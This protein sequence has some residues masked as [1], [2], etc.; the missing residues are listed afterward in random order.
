MPEGCAT[1]HRH[2]SIIDSRLSQ[3][4]LNFFVR[5]LFIFQV[6]HHQVIVGFGDL[7]DERR[8]IVAELFDHLFRHR[9]FD[10]VHGA[11]LLVGVCSFLDE[12]DYA[13]EIILDANRDLYCHGVGFQ[14]V[15]NAVDGSEEIRSYPVHLVNETDS[16]NAVLVRLPP[17]RL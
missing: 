7:L 3:R 1:E 14:P 11:F 2:D 6:L 12:I 4:L 9:P 10:G 17:D 8:P 5:Y 15:G 13:L 16:G